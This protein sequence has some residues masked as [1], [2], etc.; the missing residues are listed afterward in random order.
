MFSLW[1]WPNIG[2]C[3]CLYDL[4]LT[5]SSNINP[6]HLCF[7]LVCAQM[8]L[9]GEGHVQW[10]G[11]KSL[12]IGRPPLA[13]LEKWHT[14][15]LKGQC[16]IWF[17]KTMKAIFPIAQTS[18]LRRALD[19]RSILQFVCFWP[20]L[21]RLSWRRLKHHPLRPDE[22]DHGN[23]NFNHRCLILAI[24]VSRPLKAPS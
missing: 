5:R 14:S 7:L 6:I 3:L 2:K 22:L 15:L 10:T 23:H 12:L 17:S 16:C 1:G 9:G 11:L 20:K 4:M 24:G 13:M 18:P 21:L 8:H 19:R